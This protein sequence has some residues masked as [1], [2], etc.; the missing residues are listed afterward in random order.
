MLSPYDAG[1][2]ARERG[3][4]RIL[5]VATAAEQTEW[6][7]GWD[8]MDSELKRKNAPAKGA[9]DRVYAS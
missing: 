3:C 4:Y 1:R 2:M 8:D 7:R 5:C 6:E 9:S